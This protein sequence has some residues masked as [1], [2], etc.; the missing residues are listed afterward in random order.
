MMRTEPALNLH[1][2]QQPGPE[3]LVFS[4][5]DARVDE[6]MERL[7]RRGILSERLR[8]EESAERVAHTKAKVAVL[9]A[10][11]E[12]SSPDLRRLM[13]RLAERGLPLVCWGDSRPV[14]SDGSAAVRRFSRDAGPDE[15]VGWIAAAASYAPVVH[16]LEAELSRLERLGAQLQRHFEEVDEE[17]RLAGRLQ[18]DL[19]P[20]A[21]PAIAGVRTA[22]MYR[23][24][25]W[26]SGDC[27]DAFP[28]G[29]TRIGFF[30]GDAVG[31][32]ASAAMLTMFVRHALSMRGDLP[33]SGLD[34][35]AGTIEYLHSS[36]A[37][38]H[39]PSANYVT[40]VYAVYDASTRKLVVARGGHPY[41]IH[42]AADGRA[43]E[44]QAAGGL[45]GIGDLPPCLEPHSV[46]LSVGDKVLFFTD[47]LEDKLIVER[48]RTR[49]ETVFRE[50]L[51]QLAPL[52]A[53]EFIRA[54]REHLDRC[55]GSL[56]PADDV[57]AV[58]ME[59]CPQ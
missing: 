50:L 40:C 16:R 46:E 17:M 4:T 42:I 2:R 11:T 29:E 24:M 55:E 58:V 10:G 14:P 23:P 6:L 31:H 56:H 36:L 1:A 49:G 28:L 12:E 20:G 54:L 30:V 8:V 25:R 34:D 27:Y 44:L 51:S 35:P 52:P 5:L 32:G 19:L 26:V 53:H 21:L 38:L 3:V 9:V 15:V 45:V 33:G 47:G 48:D 13:Q 22:C 41:P 39:L 57:T 37:R 18:R 7:A 43:Q 59:V